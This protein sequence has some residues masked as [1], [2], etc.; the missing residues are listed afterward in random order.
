VAFHH[1]NWRTRAILDAQKRNPES[2]HYTVVQ[3]LDQKA[4]EEIRQKIIQLIEDA[5]RI[6]RP[7]KEERLICF[8]TDFFEV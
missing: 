3:S 6:A 7:A 8:T 1:G 4:F 5:N 2:V